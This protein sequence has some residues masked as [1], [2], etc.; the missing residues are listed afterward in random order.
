[1]IDMTGVTWR[2]SSFSN[3][4]GG[5]CVEVAGLPDG[6]LMRDTKDHGRGPILRFTESE[7]KA[8]VDGVKHADFS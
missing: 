3:G 2:T 5:M 4:N 8:F 7:W 1:M 6:R